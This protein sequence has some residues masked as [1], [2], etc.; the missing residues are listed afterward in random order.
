MGRVNVCLKR[1]YI[2]VASLVAIIGALL[3]ALTLYSHGYL[4]KDEELSE[5]LRRNL[6]SVMPL[7]D[8]SGYALEAVQEIQNKLL[9]VVLCIMILCRLN[10]KDNTPTVVY[11]PEAQAGNYITLADAADNP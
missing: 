7:S 3:L 2:I 11:S 5:D 6:L 9:S 1:S 4:H 10:Q 8:V